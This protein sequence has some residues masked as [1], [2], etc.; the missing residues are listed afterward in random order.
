MLVRIYY[1]ILRGRIKGFNSAVYA[2]KCQEVVIELWLHDELVD[3][4][5]QRKPFICAIPLFSTIKELCFILTSVGVKYNK[6]LKTLLLL[7][8]EIYSS[9]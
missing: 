1:C 6:T 9:W 7:L 2:I 5:H 8:Y 4:F 3:T